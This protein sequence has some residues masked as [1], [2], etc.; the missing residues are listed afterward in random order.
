MPSC[1]AQPTQ[2]MS[3]FTD[4]D[5]YDRTAAATHANRDSIAAS[6][7]SPSGSTG[8]DDLFWSPQSGIDIDEQGRKKKTTFGL[9]EQRSEQTTEKIDSNAGRDKYVGN[10]SP[11]QGG[12]GENKRG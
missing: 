8:E 6:S 10:A 11:S 2:F 1:L 7:K 3:N 4:D 9:A 5:V 12:K